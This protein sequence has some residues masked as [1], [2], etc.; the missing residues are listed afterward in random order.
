MKLSNPV[1]LAAGF[2]KDAKAFEALIKMGFG[3]VEIGSVTPK[4]QPGNAKPR[5]FRLPED[6]AVINRYGFNSVGHA[7]AA[8]L[9]RARPEAAAAAEAQ[10]RAVREARLGLR[11]VRILVGVVLFGRIP[12]RGLQLLL[13]EA[14]F[15]LEQ[16]VVVGLGV[17]RMFWIA[18]RGV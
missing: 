4:P 11:V 7:D 13:G 17:A 14:L 3:F 9:L 1:G 2:D 12:I 16:F 18:A 15:E 8:E 6:R 10:H 5:V